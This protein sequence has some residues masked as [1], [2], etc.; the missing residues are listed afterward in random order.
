MYTRTFTALSECFCKT[1]LSG[2]NAG[3]MYPSPFVLHIDVCGVSWAGK[4]ISGLK[5]CFY[6]WIS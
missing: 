1:K 4:L 2:S 5:N 6:S 3:L